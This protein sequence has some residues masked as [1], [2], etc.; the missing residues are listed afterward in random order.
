MTHGRIIQ[1]PDILAGKPVVQGTRIP[2]ELVL[3][4][5]ARHLDVDE[6]LADYPRLTR[7]D[8]Q[9]CLAYAGMLVER[10]PRAQ[11]PAPARQ[12]Q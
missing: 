7:E 10:Q 2:V 1:D 4:K 9:A 8:V 12:A 11:P 3:A 6:L 5:L